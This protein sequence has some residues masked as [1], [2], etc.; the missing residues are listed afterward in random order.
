VQRRGAG[1]LV[2]RKAGYKACQARRPVPQCVH[3]ARCWQ[4]T[5]SAAGASPAAHNRRT[6]HGPACVDELQLAVA[7]E[8]LRVGRQAGRVPAVVAGKLAGQV[9]G[10]LREGAQE[11]GAVGAIPACGGGRVVWLGASA[12]RVAGAPRRWGGLQGPV[13][14]DPG[15]AGTR[16]ASGAR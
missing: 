15:R 10:R 11:L 1:L 6:Q 8:R 12:G 5:S 4:A 16:G 2:A 7:A 9:A 13:T 14:A 3:A